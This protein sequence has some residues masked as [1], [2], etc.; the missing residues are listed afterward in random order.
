MYTV[1]ISCPIF[2]SEDKTKVLSAL[3][4]IFPET[5]F[6]LNGDI[7]EGIAN[8]LDYFSK[9]IRKQKILDATR[10]TLIQGKSNNKITFKLN[11]QAAFMGKISFIQEKNTI[12]GAIKVT[13]ESEEPLSVIETISPETVDGVE[14]KI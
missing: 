13:I 6:E 4:N 8:N 10:S 5:E 1:S 2:P 14:V 12:L 9:Q 11:K 7:F 3:Q